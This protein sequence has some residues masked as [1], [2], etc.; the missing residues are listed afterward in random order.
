MVS[1]SPNSP[2]DLDLRALLHGLATRDATPPAGSDGGNLPWDNPEFSKRMLREH[3]DETHGAATR[4]AGD[5]EQ[6]IEWL[7]ERVGLA[8][9]LH[10]LDVTCG[11][12]LYAVALADRG[13]SVTGIDFAPAAIEHAR[14]LAE[15]LRVDERCNFVQADVRTAHLGRQGFDVAMVLFGQVTV[16]RPDDTR[17]LLARLAEAVGPGGIVVLEVLDGDQVARGYRTSWH[18]A[19]R[20]LW[21]DGPHLALTERYW[22]DDALASVERVHV[23]SA[24]TATIQ[25][26]AVVDYAHSAEAMIQMLTAAGFGTVDV[27]PAWDG[28]PIDDAGRWIVYIATAGSR[29]AP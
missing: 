29:A 19:E 2:V 23:L 10:L 6:I 5:R 22:D 18:A 11:P 9:G 3:L 7:W 24:E 21:S 12:G 20:G 27:Y 8:P 25:T 26:F 28:L 17:D 15:E 14:A 13:A 1:E 16:F 4:R